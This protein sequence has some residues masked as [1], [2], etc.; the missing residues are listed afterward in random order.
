MKAVRA[1]SALP[2]KADISLANK[3]PRLHL[4][5]CW[6]FKMSGDGSLNTRQQN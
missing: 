3:K 6:H 1:M 2:P 4:P 5:G